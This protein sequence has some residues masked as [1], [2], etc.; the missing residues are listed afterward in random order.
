MNEEQ[1]RIKD[2]VLKIIEQLHVLK[3]F[4]P[5]VADTI[6]NV[7]DLMV[8]KVNAE[9]IYL[10]TGFNDLREN[11]ETPTITDPVVVAEIDK[12]AELINSEEEE[13]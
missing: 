11:N 10:K 1:I 7:L 13:Y 6:I 8:I 3:E 5:L 12:L 9:D 2:A 4:N